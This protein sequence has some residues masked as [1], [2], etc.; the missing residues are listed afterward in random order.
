MPATDR[1]FFAD[2]GK[3][4]MKLRLPRNCR[5]VRYSC[6]CTHTSSSSKS[7]KAST[8]RLIASCDPGAGVVLIGWPQSST[9]GRSEVAEVDA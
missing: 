2:S 3:R 8:L 6:G 4:P 1:V 9:R 5:V 7:G